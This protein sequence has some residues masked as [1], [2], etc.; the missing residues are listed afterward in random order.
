MTTICTHC[1]TEN[2]KDAAIC[3]HC[4]AVLR[5]TTPTQPSHANVVARIVIASAGM[6]YGPVLLIMVEMVGY[7]FFDL[8]PSPTHTPVLWYGPI[9]VGLAFALWMPVRWYIRMPIAVLYGAIMYSFLTSAWF[10]VG[11]FS[12]VILGCS[13][14]I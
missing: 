1:G 9:L 3:T 14:F 11:L 6:V 12:C 7:R 4:H 10:L 2:T 5:V 8:R 13:R